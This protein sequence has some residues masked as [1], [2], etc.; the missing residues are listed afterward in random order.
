MLRLLVWLWAAP[1]SLLGLL[2]GTLAWIGGARWERVDGALEIAGGR[3]ARWLAVCGPHGIDAIAFGHVVLGRDA[4]TLAALRAHEHAHVRQ[5]ER[6][7]PAFVPAYLL[8]S[9]W[10]WLRGRRPYLDNP[11]ERAARA[12]EG[13][14][15]G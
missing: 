1:W 3:M 13:R 2:L 9:A 8:G 14:T 15:R 11:F 5:Y 7:G 10:Q 6:W 4:A 12:A